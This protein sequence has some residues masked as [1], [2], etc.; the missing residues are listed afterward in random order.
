MQGYEPSDDEP[1]L[2]RQQAIEK[3]QDAIP[4]LTELQAVRDYVRKMA[5]RV[6]NGEVTEAREVIRPLLAIVGDDQ[7]FMKGFFRGQRD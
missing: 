3:H 1:E 6:A 7:M 5:E 4:P 2:L